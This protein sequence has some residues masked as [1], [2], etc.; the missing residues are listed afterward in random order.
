MS[1]GISSVNDFQ[2]LAQLRQDASVPSQDTAREAARQFEALFVQMMLKSMRDANAVLGESQDTTYQEMFD[3]QIAMEMT[4]GRG[5]GIADMMSRQLG[6]TSQ[7]PAA[8]VGTGAVTGAS[9][10]ADASIPALLGRISALRNNA[11]PAYGELQVPEPGVLPEPEVRPPDLSAFAKLNSG[12]RGDFRPASRE[13]FVREIWPLAVKAGRQLG[14]EPRAIVAQAALETGW[15]S[16]LI[17]DDAGVSGNNLFGIKADARWDG[18]RVSVATLEYE[19]GLPKPQR[20]NF[21]AY[22]DLA[23]GFDDYVRFLSENPRYREALRAG[24]DA[25]AYADRLQSSGYA[26][27]P[28]YAEK[29]RSII[30]SPILGSVDTSLKGGNELPNYL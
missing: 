4:R 10:A 3:Q 25:G 16:R 18:E 8:Q 12:V 5:L 2:G 17:R 22:P 11:A 13:E 1:A 19:G 30:A 15:G 20:A 29:I 24:A 28:R 6:I 26:T 21:R 23:A 7:Q 27:D 9:A 14:V